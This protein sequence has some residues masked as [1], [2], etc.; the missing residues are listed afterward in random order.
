MQFIQNILNKFSQSKD[1]KAFTWIYEL[2]GMDDISAI[3]F[4]EEKLNADFQRDIFKSD[5]HLNELFQ[6][7]EKIHIIVERIT[8]HY[9]NID[10]INTELEERI[11]NTVF[12]YHRQLFLIYFHLIE[13]LSPTNHHDLPMMLARAINNATQMIKWRYYSYQSAPANVWLQLSKLYMIAEQQ[14]LLH[15]SVETYFDQEMKKISTAYMEAC[16]LGTLESLS[17]KCQQIELISDM[18]AAWMER[19]TIDTVFD[20]EKHL[21]FVDTASNSPAKRIRNFK[22]ASTYR[23]WCFDDVN[24]NVELCLSLIEFNIIPKQHTVKEIIKNPF[25]LSTLEILRTEWSRLEYK[26]QRRSEDRHKTTKS[27]TTAYGFEDT[28]YQLKEYENI[29]IQA[30]DEAKPNDNSLNER[31]AFNRH[32]ISYAEPNIIYMDLGESDTNIVDESGKGIGL[33]INKHANEVSL[34]MIVCVTV[35]EEQNMTKIGAIRSIRPIAGGKLHIG[36]EVFSASAIR[37]EAKTMSLRAAQPSMAMSNTALDYTATPAS[38]ICLLL[39]I[40]NG[41]SLQET[42]VFPKSQFNKNEL[43]KINISGESKTVKPDD[44]LEQREDWVRATFI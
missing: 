11:E 30:S 26:R 20:E 41:I 19:T 36:I 4:C 13:N 7:D 6:I 18:L 29:R 15:D 34:G 24:I 43:Y 28:C 37:I 21:F 2:K 42:L 44:I 17:L 22:P 31:L 25:A 3:K 33:H 5:L 32:T 16:M 1:A 14:S 12:L 39:P 10:H 27:A 23:Y 40:E 35:K 9:I 8:T 38:F